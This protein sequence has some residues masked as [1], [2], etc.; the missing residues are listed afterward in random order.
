MKDGMSE[1]LGER[2]SRP[3]YR[4]QATGFRGA[5]AM[6]FGQRPWSPES[7]ARSLFGLALAVSLFVVP[8]SSRGDAASPARVV[9]IN[10]VVTAG[11]KPV[12]TPGRQLRA[13]APGEVLQVGSGATAQLLLRGSLGVGLMGQATVT[14]SGK[15]A[16]VEVAALNNGAVRLGGKGG[17]L[18][19]KGW[20]VEL[21]SAGAS[22]ILHGGRLYVLGGTALV[23]MPRVLAPRPVAPPAPPAD[24]E[25]GRA[26]TSTSTS[27]PVPEPAPVLPTTTTL[28]A[29]K[30]MAL[31]DRIRPATAGATPP[32]AVLRGTSDHGVPAPWRPGLGGVSA[33]DVKQARVWMQ[34]EQQAQR[35]TAACGCTEGGGAQGG[36]LGGKGAD[37]GDVQKSVTVIKIK[38]NGVP[39]K[40]K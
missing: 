40:S 22:V 24:D 13:L 36:A 29:G 5:Q 27:T 6:L 34:A 10:G 38:I 32:T 12:S 8:G 16:D 30:A 37:T 25:P 14:V 20:R 4:L 17:S 33:E 2:P 7:G 18:T 11:G 26:S 1:R 31:A 23:R 39:K 28:A 21:A 15:E 35:E 3:G 19:Y 9:S